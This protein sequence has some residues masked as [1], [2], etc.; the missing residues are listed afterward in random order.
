MHSV[1]VGAWYIELGKRF[2]VY[3]VLIFKLIINTLE[4]CILNGSFFVLVGNRNVLPFTKSNRLVRKI[5]TLFQLFNYS[6]RFDKMSFT[7]FYIFRFMSFYNFKEY[8]YTFFN[9]IIIS[10]LIYFSHLYFFIFL[11]IFMKDIWIKYFLNLK[12]L[13]LVSKVKCTLIL[14]LRE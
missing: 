4:I 10:L 1:R 7:K 5:T 2:A 14:K 6:L 8:L 12:I 11:S 9:F 3:I 13:I